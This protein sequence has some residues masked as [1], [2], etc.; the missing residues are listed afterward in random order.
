[1]GG[2]STWQF[3][4]HFAGMW[5]CVQPG[6]GFAESKEFLK[7]GT[8]EKPLPSEWEQKLWRWYD[9]TL[10]VSN[11]KN[12]TTVAYS[13]EIDGQKQACDIM[14]RFARQEAGNA[15]PPVAELN[16][17]NPG[18][19]SPKAE[20]ARVAGTA[21]DLTLY[22]VIA[23]QTPHK[24]AAE[25]KP[26]IEKL[27]GPAVEK[28]RDPA[29]KKVHFTTY[30]PIYSGPGIVALEKSRERA[31][32]D[33]EILESGVTVKT[34]NVSAIS[35]NLGDTAFPKLATATAII[36]GAKIQFSRYADKAW[37]VF[38]HKENGNW[39]KGELSN[40]AMAK[41][42]GI[43]GPIDHAFM[44][45]FVFVRPTGKQLNKV[46]GDW[47]EGE[48]SRAVTQWRAVFRGDARV[49]ADTAISEAD[50]ANSNLV[51]WGDPSSNAV[52]KKIADKLPVKW[53]AK[54]LAF[55]G[56]TYVAS[57]TASVLI[58]PS[59]LFSA[60]YVLLNCGFTFRVSAAV[61]IA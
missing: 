60:R 48:L 24:V 5:A 36:D 3:G 43:C 13:G 35:L 27:V 46:V 51:L 22:H 10:Y 19:G 61:F 31:D 26:E 12:T 16:K 52:L 1:M 8:P 44:D 33:A 55:G 20:E 21:P 59:P 15:N 6:A 34:R 47:V 40:Q 38:A 2:A 18:D 41:R 7:L 17:V 14:I 53:D 54:Q 4:T 39:V 57:T 50:I 30:T 28:G 37:I 49:I 42:E 9:S 23:P 11:L 45:S 29:P 56:K 32:L 25:A 58:F